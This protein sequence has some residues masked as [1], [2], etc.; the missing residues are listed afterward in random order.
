MSNICG[1][2]IKAGIAQPSQIRGCSTHE[3]SGLESKFE[4]RLPHSYKL[5]LLTM[6]HG[7]GKFFEG[8]DIFYPNLQKAQQSA[9]ELLADDGN[10]FELSNYDFVFASHQ[11]YQFMYFNIDDQNEDPPVFYYMEG[12]QVAQKKWHSFSDFLLKSVED[13]EKIYSVR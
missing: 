7:A 3:V 12:G 6:G 2:L 11:G 1:R 4:G 8:T 9:E 13:H 5:F 10:P